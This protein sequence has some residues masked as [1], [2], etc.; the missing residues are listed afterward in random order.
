MSLHDKMAYRATLQG[1]GSADFSKA[2]QKHANATWLYLIIAGF[3]WYFISSTW[4]LIPFAIG[5]YTALQSI[6][7]SMVATRLKDLGQDDSQGAKQ[8]GYDLNDVV[9]V[10][11]DVLQTSKPAPG[12]V[13][14]VSKLPYPKSTI[15]TALIAAIKSTE[16]AQMK[17]HLKA[18]FIMLADWQDGVGETD[19]GISVADLNQE[20]DPEKQAKKLIDNSDD[21][22]RW[23]AIMLKEQETLKQ[24]LIDLGLWE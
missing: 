14:D 23:S 1:K 5:V 6:S 7:A 22:N 4:A 17:E 24:E 2:A 15:K 20:E 9:Q 3:V 16:D 11:G 18:A 19:K 8:D 10:Y 12:T 13:A 21:F